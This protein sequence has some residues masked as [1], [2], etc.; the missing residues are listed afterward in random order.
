[1]DDGNCYTTQKPQRHKA[2][3][4]VVEPIILECERG[5][6]KDPWCIE[7]VKAMILQVRPTFPFVPREAHRRSVYTLPPKSQN[8]SCL[9]ITFA[10]SGRRVFATIRCNALFGTAQCRARRGASTTSSFREKRFHTRR[11]VIPRFRDSS[12]DRFGPRYLSTRTRCDQTTRRSLTF[13]PPRFHIRR[14]MT[15]YVILQSPSSEAER[16][17]NPEPRLRGDRVERIVGPSR[18]RQAA[19]ESHSTHCLRRT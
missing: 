19:D 6:F 5:P 1:M 8:V 17:V 2:L 4:S 15:R 9:V 10:F 16:T 14:A 13:G 7:E 3:L 11:S 12:S 18:N